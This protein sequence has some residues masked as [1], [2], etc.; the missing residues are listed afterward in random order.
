MEDKEFSFRNV[1]Q[2]D[3]KVVPGKKSELD[4]KRELQVSIDMLK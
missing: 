3:F 1:Y 2:Q 4:V